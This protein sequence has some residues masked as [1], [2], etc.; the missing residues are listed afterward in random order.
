MMQ[1]T[2]GGTGDRVGLK[3][4]R[5]YTLLAPE[6]FRAHLVVQATHAL[7]AMMEQAN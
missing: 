5:N 1:Y 4:V 6:D 3:N 2:H 7:R